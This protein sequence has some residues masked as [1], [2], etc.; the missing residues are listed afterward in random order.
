MTLAPSQTPTPPAQPDDV[1][2][3][4][5]EAR[6][7]GRRHYLVVGLLVLILASAGIAG[8]LAGISGRGVAPSRSHARHPVNPIATAADWATAHRTCVGSPLQTARDDDPKPHLYGAYPTDVRLA[9]NW[10]NRIYP[11]AGP[12]TPTTFTAGIQPRHFDPWNGY[13]TSRPATICI[14]TGAFRFRVYSMEGS[15]VEHAKVLVMQLLD[16]RPD[17]NSISIYP[18]AAVPAR[19]VPVA[20]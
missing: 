10:P 18:M 3:L 7:R 14:F 19:P 13:N 1:E 11:L 6:R 15:T 17:P 9:V 5:Q 8:V 12:P 16:I 2:V 4:I 20:G